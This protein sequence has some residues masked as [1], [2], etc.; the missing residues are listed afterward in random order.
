MFQKNVY[1]RRVSK[2]QRDLQTRVVSQARTVKIIN[3]QELKIITYDE[4]IK[5]KQFVFDSEIKKNTMKRQQNA[6]LNQTR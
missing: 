2:F 6:R 1:N 5:R 4:I 3:V